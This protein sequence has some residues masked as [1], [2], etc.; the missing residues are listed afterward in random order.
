MGNCCTASSS[1]MEWGGEDWESL[2]SS[3]PRKPCPSSSSKVFDESN[4]LGKLRGSSDANGKVKLK[5]SKSEL[6][7]LLV[8]IEQNNNIDQQQPQ[9][10]ELA[11]AEEVLIRLMKTR[12][13]QII[14]SHWKPVLDTIHEC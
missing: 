14:S 1:S 11:S 8:A 7:E 6:A 12:D 4:L 13:H 3:P 2:R 9:K 10:K 5:I